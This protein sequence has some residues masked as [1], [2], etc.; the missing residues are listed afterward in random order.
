MEVN[1]FQI[2]MSHFIFNILKMWY[3]YRANKK[4]KPEY[5]LHRRLTG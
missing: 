4:W 1:S 2:L 3:L 5:M